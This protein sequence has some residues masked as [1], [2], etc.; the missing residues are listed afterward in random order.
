MKF[1]NRKTVHSVIIGLISISI[2]SCTKSESIVNTSEAPVDNSLQIEKKK[3]DS[4]KQDSIKRAA[5]RIKFS[6]FLF[7][8]NGKDSAMA[9]FS[10]EFTDEEQYTILAL[11]RLDRKN[12][13]RAD[14][15]IIPE[16]IET[17]FLRYSPFPSRLDSL[18]SVKKMVFFSYAIHAYAL[19]EGGNLVKWGPSSLGKKATPTKKGLMFA[20]WKKEVAI[21]TSN[22]EWKL[23]WNFNIH[24]T[25]GIGWHQYDLPGFHASHS[26]LRLLEEDAKWMY[27][28]ADQWILANQGQ[29]VAAKGTPVIVFGEADFTNKPWLK[30]L[31]DPTA[32]DISVD[33][34]NGV[35][36]PH[37]KEILSE[38]KNSEA[39]RSKK[40]LSS[41]QEKGVL[42]N[43]KKAA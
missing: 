4:I 14:T 28:W 18:Q 27:T 25:A 33:E 23:R 20:N 9:A 7:P 12:R 39:L 30:L 13:W 43:K 1:S 29:T 11:N 10:K 22:S 32:N 42:R 15:L 8:K 5:E 19:Y 31:S 35:F 26:C 37:L 3:S 38:Q 6:S 40:L 2:I 36:V 34:M 21:S 16:K 24:N 17:D 41:E